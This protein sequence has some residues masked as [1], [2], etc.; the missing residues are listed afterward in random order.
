MTRECFWPMRGSSALIVVGERGL[1]GGALPD[2]SNDF[3]CRPIGSPF[4]NTVL[5]R[6]FISV[7]YCAD[8]AHSQELCVKGSA[9]CYTTYKAVRVRR[10]GGWA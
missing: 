2:L 1:M 7:T 6:V 10:G 8:K 5:T 9:E 4:S 3:S